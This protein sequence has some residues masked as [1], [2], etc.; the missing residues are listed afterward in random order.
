L[1]G[2]AGAIRRLNDE[3]LRVVVITNQRGI[4]LGRLTEERLVSIHAHMSRLL[5]L[6]SGAHVDGVFYCPHQIGACRCRKP[7]VGLFLQARERWPDIDFATSAMV[8]D[9]DA[10]T[11]AGR[12]LGMAT[13]QLG[14]D[15]PDLTAAVDVLLTESS[16]A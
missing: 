7:G 2:A 14:L 16:H 1:G 3:G 6:E 15:V 13:L 5:E 4:A 8:G 10:D 9:S 11:L 12:A